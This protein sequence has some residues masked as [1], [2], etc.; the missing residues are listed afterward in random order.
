MLGCGEDDGG[1]V[2]DNERGRLPLELPA[3]EIDAQVLR[4][5]DFLP[6]V[7]SGDYAD[8]LWWD[9]PGRAWKSAARAIA[10]RDLRRDGGRWQMRRDGRWQP[11]DAAEAAVHLTRHEAEAWC[12]WA[13]RRLPTEGEWERAALTPPDRFRWGDDWEWTAS[14]YRPFPGFVPHPY[15]DYS[16]PWFDDRPVLRGASHLTQPRL[17]DPRYRN[18][19]AADRRDVPAGFR[20]CAA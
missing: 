4:W 6:F 17:R 9:D 3:T 10:P 20:S 7:D 1:F 16:A 15:R 19:F 18:F 13:G 2:F 8:D 12:R 11:L 14:P 5:A